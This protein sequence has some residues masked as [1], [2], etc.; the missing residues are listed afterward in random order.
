MT[1]ISENRE[2]QKMMIILGCGLLGVSYFLP[3]TI[4][5]QYLALVL[6]ILAAGIAIKAC[7]ERLQNLGMKKI[8][9]LWSAIPLVE[10]ALVARLPLQGNILFQLTVAGFLLG[11]VIGTVLLFQQRGFERARIDDPETVKKR[12][13]FGTEL[14]S[15]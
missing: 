12:I 4:I 5:G 7:G 10:A 8:G 15:Q 2:A 9:L 13:R 1:K 3:Q 14:Q 6:I 11:G